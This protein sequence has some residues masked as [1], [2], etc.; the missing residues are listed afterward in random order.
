MELYVILR[1]RG[2]TTR[3]SLEHA[4]VRARRVEDGEMP[5]QVSWIRTYVLEEVDG[6]LGTLC[7]FEASGIDAIR[8]HASLAD[9]PADEIVRV[10]DTVVLRPDPEHEPSAA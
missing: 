4:T 10:L 1:R 9:L 7:V 5:D 2:W 8:K 6:S 3:A